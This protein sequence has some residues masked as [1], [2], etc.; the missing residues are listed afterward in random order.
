MER[1]VEQHSI[2]TSRDSIAPLGLTW[3]PQS[4]CLGIGVRDMEGFSPPRSPAL[5]VGFNWC[6]RYDT[7]S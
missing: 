4:S 7:D 1:V 5:V 2:H 6:A 3:P